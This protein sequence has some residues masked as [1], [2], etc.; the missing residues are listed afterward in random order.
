MSNIT[1]G[2]LETTDSTSETDFPEL[3]DSPVVVASLATF[4]GNDP[5]GVRIK[6]VSSGRVK[7]F[8]EEETSKDDETGHVRELIQFIGVSQGA[9]YD[10]SGSVIGEARVTNADQ[11]DRGEW[12]TINLNET[13][14][15]PVVF[16]QIM[17][18]EGGDPCHVR[19]RNVK[20]DSFEFQ[21]EEWNYLNGAHVEE[22]IGYVVLEKG[23]HDLPDGT[24]LEV[25]TVPADHTWTDAEFEI[26]FGREPVV[27][28]RSQTQHGR[29]EIVTRHRNL[30]SK[31]VDVRVQEEE[32]NN[33]KHTK[34]TIGILATTRRDVDLALGRA[35]G[36]T[37]EWHVVEFDS[38]LSATPI[39]LTSIETFNGSDPASSR[40]RNLTPTA[41]EVH[42]E[43]E[44]SKSSETEHLEETV[45]VVAVPEGPLWDNS[46]NKIGEAGRLEADQPDADHWHKL[47][48]E[49]S[50]SDP[51]V[52]MEIMTRNGKDP[53]HI[54][55]RNVESGGCDFKI[56]EWN[57]L[58]G[59]HTEET[60][61]YFVVE[62][63]VHS[64]SDGMELHVGRTQSDHTWSG[65]VGFIPDFKNKQPALI[66][67][68][69]T[70]N[71]PHEVVTRSTNLDAHGFKVRLQEEEARGGAH[72]AED[73]GFLGVARPGRTVPT[74]RPTEFTSKVS[75]FLPSTCGFQFVNGEVS[76]GYPLPQ[77][78]RLP[79]PVPDIKEI[80]DASNG[81]CGGMVYAAYDYYHHDMSPWPDELM[82]DP[83]P[84]S[85][86][87]PNVP[88][89]NSK[90]FKYLSERLF[91]SFTGGSGNKL[92]AALYQ[93]LM[94]SANTKKW[95]Q[96][97]KSRNQVMKEQ[98]EDTIKPSLDRGDLCPLGLIH[99]DTH[100]K[101]FKTGLNKIG[102][103]HQVLA[104]GYKKSGRT[105]EIYVYD[106]N[107][108]NDNNRRI[109]FT[110]KSDLSNW[111]EPKN[112]GS[113]KPLYAFFA[114][115]YS[116]KEPP[117]F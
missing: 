28:G 80:G 13:Y 110:K 62:K 95:G 45:S 85:P 12:H 11:A 82:E 6:D 25:L 22:E 35:E 63:G 15:D 20:S 86:T 92:G 99:V 69:Q 105:I 51:V 50:Y 31:G 47:S 57:Y 114:P 18:R 94:N 75:G 52:F 14:D 61:G 7:L 116:P 68:C 66:T 30:T 104:Y 117:Q 101:P 44:T 111:F 65:S 106:P 26:N 39:A 112:L 55:L 84:N 109:R 16:A 5:A 97:K 108:P 41:L 24:P 74:F 38:R 1:A 91:D 33:G 8:V 29:D 79:G 27:V 4:N 32:A 48:F 87:S 88:D 40:I 19:I 102:N 64:L 10:T 2:Q 96:V 115:A 60:I 34:E 3:D 81:M 78:I 90:L 103:N 56:E 23:R 59:P 21:I 67:R 58:N 42:I 71:G 54:R 73:V 37:D 93:T 70:Y 36:V 46:G 100:G 43:E 113:N 49:D 98:W 53:C 72:V 76:G 17:S 77:P 9:I 83:P 107:Y 89:E